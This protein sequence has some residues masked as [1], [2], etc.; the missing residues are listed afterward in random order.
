MD[1]QSEQ[2]EQKLIQAEKDSV[3]ALKNTFTSIDTIEFKRTG[4]DKITG[5]YGFFI[6][7]TVSNHKSVEF[8]YS[9]S[10]HDTKIG[11]FLIVDKEIQKEGKTV[12]SV[13]VVYSDGDEGL[14]W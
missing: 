2:R 14:I 6:K 9:Y 8:N 12:S 11:D 3:V 7:M 5:S 1:Y 10:N 13:K 4:Y